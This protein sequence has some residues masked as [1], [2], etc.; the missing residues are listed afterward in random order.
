MRSV[1][2]IE[3]HGIKTTKANGNS[4]VVHDYGIV[5]DSPINGMNYYKIK[6]VSYA[7]ECTVF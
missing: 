6:E 2:G 4:N 5:D 1:D 3:S 7:W